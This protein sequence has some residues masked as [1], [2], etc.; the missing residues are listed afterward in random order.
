MKKTGS[1]QD[2]PAEPLER[3]R[4]QADVAKQRVRIAK[5]ELKR[6]RKR[7][8]EA[9][10]EARRARKQS[11]AAR[12]VWKRARRAQKDKPGS[13]VVKKAA[14][15]AKRSSAAARRPAAAQRAAP[16]R[17]AG[18][19]TT[20]RRTRRAPRRARRAASTTSAEQ[21]LDEQHRDA[22]LR[23]AFDLPRIA[24]ALTDPQL[25]CSGEQVKTWCEQWIEPR[26]A[27][28]RAHPLD[29]E[30]VGRNV[31][32]RV[33]QEGAAGP[34]S[35]PTR[36]LRRLRLRRYLRTPSRGF[37]ATHSENLAPEETEAVEMCTALV[38]AARR[39]YARSA[40]HDTT[41]Q[42]NLARL[43]VLR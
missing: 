29:Y 17:T 30:R 6:A 21:L 22:A 23:E 8:K 31:S 42:T 35:V 15:R 38:E 12:K 18:S 14:A 37:S 43:A 1:E 33:R 41:V 20:R 36:A 13:K 4:L 9:K 26:G 19:A 10:R 11:I 25:R 27:E 32:E 5:E 24:V 3:A 40:C 16:K 7:L 28:R 34:E 2:T 39:W